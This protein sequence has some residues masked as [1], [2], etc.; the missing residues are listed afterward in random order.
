MDVKRRLILALAVILVLVNLFTMIIVVTKTNVLTTRAVTSTGEASICIDKVP[1]IDTISD[2]TAT[3]AT[4]FT[5]R[6][7]VTFFGSNT[8]TK[9]YDDSSLF[10]I[11]QSGYISFTPVSANVGTHPII[12]TAED[13]SRC[14]VGSKIN[15]TEDFSLTV[16]EVAAADA[17]DAAGAAGGGGGTA[18]T[19][20]PEIRNVSF[21]LSDQIL[22]VALRQSRS[23]QKKVI[24][25]NDGETELAMELI[26][27]LE[28]VL[29]I[30]PS[31]F[32]L[33][34][35]QE[36]SV[37]FVFNPILRAVPNI[38]SGFVTVE[39]TFGGKIKK[40]IDKTS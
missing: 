40:D 36:Q 11:N 38:Y 25:T 33:Q 21:Q 12:I 18:G 8:T 22:R 9:Y 28:D 32:D 13:A 20:A 3:V 23:L 37:R 24:V 29:F 4:E 26:N 27:P 16:S 1:R 35:G 7:G 10:N 14:V 34:P 31:S 39:G 17:A 5:L 19:R 15:T 6:V 30:S 2:Q